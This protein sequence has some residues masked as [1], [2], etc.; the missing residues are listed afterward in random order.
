VLSVV[1]FCGVQLAALDLRHS[2]CRSRYSLDSARNDE[3]KK[4]EANGKLI[5]ALQPEHM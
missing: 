4:K 2:G 3:T 1:A 5:P